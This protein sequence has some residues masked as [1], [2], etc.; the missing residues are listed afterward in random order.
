M[1]VVT[2]TG[3]EPSV[4]ATL[5]GT[6]AAGRPPTAMRSAAAVMVLA[7]AA[8]TAWRNR[9]RAVFGSLLL[10]MAGGGAVVTYLQT[11]TF[12]RGFVL[13]YLAPLL[14]YG[15]IAWVGAALIAARYVRVRLAGSGPRVEI[16]RAFA[17]AV[18]AVLVGLGLAA[19]SPAVS[20]LLDGA[21]DPAGP[22]LAVEQ[23]AALVPGECFDEGVS[24]DAPPD[25][26][27]DIWHLVNALDKLGVRTS[28]A[29]YM[30]RHVGPGHART[31][32]EA[33]TLTY[34]F[35]GW[36]LSV[37]TPGEPI[38]PWCEGTHRTS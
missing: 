13:Y 27:S 18:P 21:A 22:K 11:A 29:E 32:F 4:V 36:V 31:G 1:E 35:D 30:E 2:L 3:S 17:F 9:R 6:I 24:I 20:T 23:V 28:V 25:R 34:P 16:P 19:G 7:A 15:I 37:G 33:A 8:A 26:I 5:Y 14:G 12:Q 38:A 10:T